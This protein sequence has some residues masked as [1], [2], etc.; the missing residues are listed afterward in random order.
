[1]DPLSHTSAKIFLAWYCSMKIDEPHAHIYFLK[2]VFVFRITTT[3]NPHR[4]SL[5]LFPSAFF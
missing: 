5:I 2:L 1:M 3:Y 4:V